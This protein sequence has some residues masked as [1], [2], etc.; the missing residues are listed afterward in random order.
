MGQVRH[1]VLTKRCFIEGS[2]FDSENPF[3]ERA[4]GLCDRTDDRRHRGGDAT[5]PSFSSSDPC[6]SFA[7]RLGTASS[8]SLISMGNRLCAGNRTDMTQF[9]VLPASAHA[10]TNARQPASTRRLAGTLFVNDHTWRPVGVRFFGCALCNRA[11]KH[12]EL[13]CSENEM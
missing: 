4:I 1:L 9:G 12:Y 11:F 13:L 7:V 8:G 10:P 6:L 5:S 3:S 2:S